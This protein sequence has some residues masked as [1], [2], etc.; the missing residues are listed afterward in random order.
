MNWYLKVLK[1]F[2]TLDGRARRLE[3]WM[4]TLFDVIF[5]I[6]SF[7]IGAVLGRVLNLDEAM[8]GIGLGLALCLLYMLVVLMPKLSVTVRRLHDTDRS[9]LWLL[10]FLIPGI[11]P[12]VLFVMMILEGTQGPN[13]Y[14]P[15]P[16]ATAE[17]AV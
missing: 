2:A 6:L 3:Y 7:V 12:L 9:A 17:P 11:G 1:N 16:K 15:D 8:G 10:V 14:G 4:F 13:Q 5:T